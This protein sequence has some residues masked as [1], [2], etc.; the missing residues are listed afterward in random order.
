MVFLLLVIA[1]TALKCNGNCPGGCDT[2]LCG[3]RKNIVDIR[4]WCSKYNWNQANCECIMAKESEAN[5]KAV[6]QNKDGSYDVGLWQINIR[7]WKACNGGRAPCD[8]RENLGCAKD[9]YNW[10]GNSW[11][12]WS[13]CK[14]C[15]ACNSPQKND[16]Y[17]EYNKDRQYFNMS[18]IYAN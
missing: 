9:I 18:M 11:S 12:L 13:T 10:G 5:A 3:S 15:N 2:C 1:S 6:H 17:M 4:K 14:V 16:Q 7:N 8:P